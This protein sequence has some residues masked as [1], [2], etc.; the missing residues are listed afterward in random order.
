[1]PE[2]RPSDDLLADSVLRTLLHGMDDGVLAADPSGQVVMANPAAERLLGLSLVG[3]TVGELAGRLPHLLADRVTPCPADELPLTRALRGEVV[4]DAEVFVRPAGRPDGVWVGMRARPLPAGAVVVLRDHTQRKALEDS[5]AL[6]LSLVESLPLSLFRKDLAGRFTFVNGAFCRTLGLSAE[7]VIGRTDADFLPA[8]MAE[9][10]RR[11]EQ[12]AVDLLVVLEGLEEHRPSGCGFHCRCGGHPSLA[13]SMPPEPRYIQTLLAPVFDADGV[14]L[15][16]QGAFWNVTAQKRAERQLFR[17]AT[18]LRRLNDELA[19]SNADLEHFASMASHDLQEPLR[20]VAGYTQ[21]LQ[22]RYQGRL[23][24]DADDFIGFVVDGAERMQGLIN[25]LLAY[26]RVGMRSR[27]FQA[28]SSRAALDRAVANLTTAIRESG[29]AVTCE[30]LPDVRADPT[31]LTQLFQNL[32]A[33]AVKFRRGT[34]RIHV[35]V[36]CEQG[37]WVFSVQDNGIG[38]EEE[39]HER[40]FAIFQRLHTREEYAGSGVGLAICKKI[41]ERH[42]GRIWVASEVGVGSVFHFTLPVEWF[43]AAD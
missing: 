22:R 16:L 43:E 36:R 7:E 29:A 27:P 31:Q 40:I 3:L 24:G 39:Y 9:Q 32:V 8:S 37:D 5:R 33:N 17:T 41:V 4:E 34:P 20:M 30:H 14:V 2:P 25:D 38:I 28:T 1:M 15:G 10:H 18:D 21:L 11:D 19:R 35:S 23:D 13:P 6:H 12:R 42:H 26:A